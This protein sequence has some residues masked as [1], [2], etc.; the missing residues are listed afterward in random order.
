MLG[1]LLL[2]EPQTPE[3]LCP[4]QSPG[5]CRF[6]LSGGASMPCSAVAAF[7]GMLL[8]TCPMGHHEGCS[9]RQTPSELQPLLIGLITISLLTFTCPSTT[10][11]L[12]AALCLPLGTATAEE[13]PQPVGAARGAASQVSPRCAAAAPLVLRAERGEEEPLGIYNLNSS[14]HV[15]QCTGCTGAFAGPASWIQP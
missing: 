8:P 10:L 11:L 9:M 13:P 3:L 15:A 4:R 1:A 14:A 6:A 7:Q 2:S 12:A 5:Q